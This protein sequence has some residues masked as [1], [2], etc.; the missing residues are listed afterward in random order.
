MFHCH[1][2]FS[3]IPLLKSVLVLLIVNFASSCLMTFREYPRLGLRLRLGLRVVQ[4]RRGLK[5]LTRKADTERSG[6]NRGSELGTATAEP[7]HP[8]LSPSPGPHW[9]WQPD[10][11]SH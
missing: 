2:N 1:D 4:V 9:H 3:H 7:S 5:F 11:R 6:I 8:S 10:A